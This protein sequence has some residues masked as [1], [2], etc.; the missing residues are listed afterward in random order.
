LAEG[1]VLL[2][3]FPLCLLVAWG[4]LRFW[5]QNWRKL[6][7]SWKYQLALTLGLAALAHTLFLI[8]YRVLTSYGRPDRIIE[9]PQGRFFLLALLPLS[10]IFFVGLRMAIPA[11]LRKLVPAWFGY[12]LWFFGLLAY[13]LLMLFGGFLPYYYNQN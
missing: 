8:L 11:R 2:A 1:R 7:L 4:S 3:F 6:K 13:A 12:Y 10:A 5:W 9:F